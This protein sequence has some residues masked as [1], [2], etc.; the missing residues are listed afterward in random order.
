MA[1]K[2]VRLT[3]REDEPTCL[4]EVATLQERE[5]PNI[6]PLLASYTLENIESECNVLSLHFIFPLAV[7]G[8]LADWMKRA[9]PPDWLQALPAPDRRACLYRF[10]YALVSGLSF[11]HR[12]KGGT[13]TAHHDLKPKNILVFGQ[14][15]KIADFG[16]SHLRFLYQGSAT[17][18][19][20]HLGTY[21]YQPP[22]YWE[23]DG[24]RALVEHG[25][26]FDLW[27]LGCIIIEIA[28]LIAY[29]WDPT[30]MV[31]FK[32]RRRKNPRKGKPKLAEKHSPDSSFHKTWII[33]EEW[34]QELQTHD[35]SQKFNS[36]LNVALLMMHQDRDS[37]LYSWEAEWDLYNI[38]RPDDNRVTRLEKGGLCVQPPSLQGKILNG[39]QRP[40]HRAARQGDLDRLCM[41]KEVGWPLSVQDREGLTAVDIFHRTQQPSA[42]ETLSARLA[43]RLPKSAAAIQQG[44]ELLQAAGAGNVMIVRHLLAQ[45]V[46]ASYAN[47]AS[48]QS[49]LFK[50]AEKDRPD[51]AECLLQA[52]GKKLLRQ[53]DHDWHDTP[54]HCSASRGHTRTI[55]RLMVCALDI[56]DQQKQG[57]TA[58]Y[59]AVESGCEENVDI[60]LSH[61]AQVFSQADIQDTPVHAAA[62]CNNPRILK[63]LLQAS[64]A[65]KCL[66]HKDIHGCTPLWVAVFRGHM[67]CA[68]ILLDHKASLHVSNVK[69]V[70]VLQLAID[71]DFFDF[72]KQ[73][74]DKF[75]AD[76]FENRNIWDQTP[77]MI[78]QNRGKQRFVDLIQRA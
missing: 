26:A 32:D 10:I 14:E 57:K 73:H 29:D 61:E 78:A 46:D 65:V 19:G 45:R 15:L 13:I 62:R 9:R 39:T 28:T 4:R 49:A 31:E 58:L 12:E 51:V 22:E 7:E 18:A 23:Q 33:V 50:A 59:L 69:R 66:E 41:L 76:D 60:L 20:S 72:V 47:K 53:R 54:L 40:V 2:E 37:R 27:S 48:G 11:L 16:R 8:D 36:T 1:E 42:C 71:R 77:L 25:R 21:E 55:K 6:V 30:K 75:G 68:N 67:E 44:E 56:E 63:R 35:G 24:T 38:Q 3:N 43:P 5:H 52:G 64:D 34:V 70:N 17:E 74:R